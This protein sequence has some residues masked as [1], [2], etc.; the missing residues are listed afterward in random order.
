MQPVQVYYSANLDVG[1]DSRM[2]IAAPLG[3]I[4]YQDTL[5]LGFPV[6]LRENLA[7]GPG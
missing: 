3:R 1:P 7:G 4:W 6:K 2:Y 5:G